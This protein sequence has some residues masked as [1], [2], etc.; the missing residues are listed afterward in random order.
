MRRRNYSRCGTWH[1]T[2]QRTVTTLGSIVGYLGSSRN[3]VVKGEKRGSQGSSATRTVQ[4]H[5]AG[6]TGS[7]SDH[8]LGEHSHIVSDRVQEMRERRNNRLTFPPTDLCERYIRGELQLCLRCFHGVHPFPLFV[9]AAD[10]ERSRFG[11]ER[12][13]QIPETNDQNQRLVFVFAIKLIED[14]KWI[15]RRIRSV[16][17]LEPFDE[18]TR[19]G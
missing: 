5:D 13:P 7:V 2:A 11:R 9:K 18:I 12:G 1:R 8:Q 14:E 17:W 10:D 3:G 16:V 19:S 6:S 4:K 15:I